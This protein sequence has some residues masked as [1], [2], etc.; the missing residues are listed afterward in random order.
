[1]RKRPSNNNSKTKLRSREI[2]SDRCRVIRA[3]IMKMRSRWSLRSKKWQSHSI[4][5]KLSKRSYR[6]I[7]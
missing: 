5:L 2:R 1:M 4:K 7:I 3:K 6:R